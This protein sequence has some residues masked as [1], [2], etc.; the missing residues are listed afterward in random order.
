MRAA[1]IRIDFQAPPKRGLG[2]LHGL[3]GI[4]GIFGLHVE[5]AQQVPGNRVVRQRGWQRLVRRV[6]LLSDIV[7]QLLFKIIGGAATILVP[8]QKAFS[9]NRPGFRRDG[10]LLQ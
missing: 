9:P 4:R 10:T 6:E 3:V 7:R 1:K 5:I 8:L 2:R